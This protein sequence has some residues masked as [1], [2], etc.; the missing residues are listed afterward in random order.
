VAAALPREEP[1]RDD[2]FAR[3]AASLPEKTIPD[4][5][6]EDTDRTFP[7]VRPSPEP[8]VAARDPGLLEFGEVDLAGADVFAEARQKAFGD[9][10]PLT[11]PARGTPLSS[12]PLAGFSLAELGTPADATRSTS[13]LLPPPVEAQPLPAPAPPAPESAGEGHSPR[14]PRQP[15]LRD[16]SAD[17]EQDAA[18][19]AERSRRRLRTVGVNALSLVALV[20]LAVVLFQVWRGRQLVDRAGGAASPAVALDVVSAPYDTASGRQVVV[21]RG[22]VQ[23]AQPLAR[24][25]VRVALLD[26]GRPVATGRAIAGAVPSAEEVHAIDTT[27]DVERL[28]Q[29]SAARAPSRIAAGEVL[30]FA[31]VVAEPPPDLSAVEVRVSVRAEPLAKD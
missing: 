9:L 5:A 8:T 2:P 3:A 26:G 29:A 30:P 23:A 16:A 20:V 12:D 18:A 31:V 22:R 4:L 14:L 7:P 13:D 15:V 11:T 28:V 24:A 10:A 17:A 6:L 27:A 21:V 1:S 19:E 25:E